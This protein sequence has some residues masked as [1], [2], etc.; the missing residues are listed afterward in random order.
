MLDHF[1][2]WMNEIGVELGDPEGL[3]ALVGIP[4]HDEV[5]TLA[6][7]IR[8]AREGLKRMGL[9]G[10]SAILC[11]GPERGRAV[12]DGALAA[13]GEDEQIPVRGVLL[14]NG[15]DG[16][17]W[18]IRAL[19]VLAAK[20]RAPLV[21]LP[22]DLV[23]VEVGTDQNGSG[24]SPAWIERLLAPIGED[25]DLA[26]ARFNRHPLAKSV[27]SLLAFPVITGVFGFR[28]RQPTSRVVAM[29]SRLI[30]LGLSASDLWASETGSYGFDAWLVTRALVGG[31]SVCEVPLGAVAH[32]YDIGKLKIAFHQVAHAVLSEVALHEKTW[33]ER[34]NTISS[35][36]VSGPRFDVDPP[37]FDVRSEEL[38]R[39]FKLEFNHFDDTL[40]QRIMPD[41]YRERIERQTDA[42]SNEVEI[43]AEEWILTLQ[44][45]L[46]AYRFET[47]FH[48]DDIVDG[49]F[50]FFLG[51]LATYADEYHEMVD[52]FSRSSEMSRKEAEAIA[53]REAE[54][55]LQ[56]QADLF[57]E[58][59]PGFKKSWREREREVTSYLPR[60]SAWQ[61]VPNVEVIVPQELDVPGGNSVWAYQ[62]YTEQINK[63]RDQ[64]KQFVSEVLGIDDY[65]RSSSVLEG[66]E[67]FV[68]K[69]DRMLEFDVFPYDITTPDG[70][71]KM[72]ERACESFA[73]GDAFRLTEDAIRKILLQAPPANLI[74]RLDVGNI[75]GLLEKL[76]P[77]DALG[78]AAW[79]DQVRY[80]ARILDIIERDGRPSWFESAPVKTEVIDLKFLVNASE[81]GGPAA[82]ARL[83]GR[84]V[85]A[86]TQRGAG[87]RFPKLWYMLKLIK[88]IVS[89]ESFSDIWRGFAEEGFDFG[90]RLVTSVRGHWGRRVLSAHNAFENGH[91]RIVVERLVRFATE[92][93]K[94][95]PEKH[96]AARLLKAAASV[97]HLSITLPDTTFVPLSVW[98]WASFSNRG[99]VGVPTP[100]SSLVERDWA[101][102]DFFTSYLE[103]AG[104]GDEETVNRTIVKLISKGK[105][106]EALS[107]HLMGVEANPD[108][109]VV[110]Q[111]PR[112]VPPPAG[113]L[114]RALDKPLLEPVANHSWESRYV[115]NAAAVRVDGSVHI[116]YRAF[117]DDE[118]SRIGMAWSK[119]GIHI[120]GRLDKPIFEPGHPT[121]TSGVEDPRVVIMDGRL[122][123]L[124]T[125]WDRQVAQIAMAS[126]Q[127]EDFLARRFDRWERHGL[128][129]PGLANKDAVLYPE[130]INGRYV[131]YHR[132]D[133]NMWITYM[134][135]LACPWPRTG[136]QIIAGPRSGMMWDGV[137]IGAGGQP[138]KTTHGWLNIYH[139]VD[140]ERSY[141][142][143]VLFMPLDDPAKV[144]YRSPNP[145]LEPETDYELGDA[146]GRDAWVPHVVFTCGAVP[147]E[148]VEIV[149]PDDEILVYYGAADTVI[150][151][152]RETL[153]G[154]VPVI[155]SL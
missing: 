92:L 136:Q 97:Y 91:Q 33:L 44:R 124:Y 90:K 149:G 89:L 120:D 130:K 31:L 2:H 58:A 29:S 20:K 110:A 101:T 140:Y 139:G 73:A 108:T 13:A 48:H 50:P 30:H 104:R 62:V 17:G 123:M 71:R 80:L 128:G 41:E 146:G 74:F 111:T 153:R 86:N 55:R 85:V 69:L 109:L 125:A 131:L 68:Y 22:P 52:S 93:E 63:Y 8:T 75:R 70:A 77:H 122:I 45:F 95:Q 106:S 64:F 38:R 15:L 11:S 144:I 67:S 78:L 5:D 47:G 99:G 19:M 1:N 60:L 132:I 82:L 141:R 96:E 26:L 138:I 9:S 3:D 12:L 72:A 66:V 103:R 51:R 39:R 61:F 53:R 16:R 43:T 116:L 32:R 14:E 148:D 23:P 119:D 121:E 24:F 126:I 83:A 107:E 150:G 100:L 143:G 135:D 134:D 76:E 151:V 88:S 56:E 40:F 57:V 137:K 34:G 6:G 7:V 25:H 36:A 81:V 102:R 54:R 129:F 133:P 37:L 27:E 127:V 113:K 98:T 142:L 21:L 94:T 117:G 118:V 42:N 65:T 105:E 112:A 10:K 114:V 115:L 28:L 35:P 84:V 59:W 154:L 155:D 145:V 87:G 4:F 147:A 49:L 152:A 79:T 18:S 46:A